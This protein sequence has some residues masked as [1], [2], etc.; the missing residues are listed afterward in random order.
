[1][2][3]L[4]AGKLDFRVAPWMVG[5]P[6]ALEKKSGGFRP[7]AIGEVIRRLASRLCCKAAHS[8]LPDIFLPYR[9]VGVGIRGG[10]EAAFHSVNRFLEAHGLEEDLCCVKLI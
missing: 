5:A 10:L 2:N 6:L 3:V 8:L 4:L 7:I 1:M 9:Q